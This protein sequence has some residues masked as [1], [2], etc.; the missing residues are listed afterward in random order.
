MSLSQPPLKYRRRITDL[1]EYQSL[2]EDSI[3]DPADYWKRYSIGHYTPAGN[4]LFAYAIRQ[5]VVDWLE[6]KP[7]TYRSEEAAVDFSEYLPQH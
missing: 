1:D 4:H 5:S 6:P 3:A 2:Y 7:L